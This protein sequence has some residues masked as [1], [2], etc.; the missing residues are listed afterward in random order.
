MS[1]V[2]R[3]EGGGSAPRPRRGI[4]QVKDRAEKRATTRLRRKSS[5]EVSL[6]MVTTACGFILQDKHMRKGERNEASLYERIH[7]TGE[8]PDRR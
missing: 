2:R 3:N 8:P 5:P 6:G 4:V 1:V 7:A